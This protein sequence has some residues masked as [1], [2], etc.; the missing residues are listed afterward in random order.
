MIVDAKYSRLGRSARSSHVQQVTSYCYVL[1]AERGFL[2]YADSL[3][4]DPVAHLVGRIE[5][6]EYPLNLDQRPSEL[7][8]QI[9]SLAESIARR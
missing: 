8:E 3:V 2:V 6:T 9:D 4:S 7:L 1:G 5:I